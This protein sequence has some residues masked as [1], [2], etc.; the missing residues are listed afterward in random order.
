MKVNID[1]NLNY[2]E[3]RDL[4]Y[5]QRVTVWDELMKTEFYAAKDTLFKMGFDE[6]VEL[7]A[8]TLSP[9]Q[10]HIFSPLATYRVKDSSGNIDF[11]DIFCVALGGMLITNEL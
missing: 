5:P 6:Y 9:S 4:P 1:L 8:L 2:S 3:S 10:H 11:I 7:R